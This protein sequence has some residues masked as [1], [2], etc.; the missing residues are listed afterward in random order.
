MLYTV[1]DVSEFINH[2]YAVLDIQKQMIEYLTK[3]GYILGGLH[4]FRYHFPGEKN[5]VFSYKIHTNDAINN[6]FSENSNVGA[7]E[8]MKKKDPNLN[9]DVEILDEIIPTL[10]SFLKL[11]KKTLEKIRI[12][13]PATSTIVKPNGLRFI[14]RS[15]R[16]RLEKLINYQKIPY[17]NDLYN[18]YQED[19]YRFVYNLSFKHG[20]KSVPDSWRK[21]LVKVQ[22]LRIT[23]HEREREVRFIQDKYFG[24]ACKIVDIKDLAI[25]LFY[26]T[27]RLRVEA[28]KEN[29]AKKWINRLNLTIDQL[30]HICKLYHIQ[31]LDDDKKEMD[32]F[33]VFPYYFINKLRDNNWHGQQKQTGIR[34]IKEIKAKMCDT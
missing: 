2:N 6:G 15:A 24:I 27:I 7:L 1:Q 31:Y 16:P 11:H 12:D 18:Q 26:E 3:R 22:L 4:A 8:F 25:N 5:D 28:Y 21:Y 32:F 20:I 34:L 9:L 23:F 17:E 14:L 10:D 13:L 19:S 30:V 29:A 33:N